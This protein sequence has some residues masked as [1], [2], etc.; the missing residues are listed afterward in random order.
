MIH[1]RSASSLNDQAVY[2][3]VA[4]PQLNTS[5]KDKDLNAKYQ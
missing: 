5:F 3:Y 2:L 1:E 4:L